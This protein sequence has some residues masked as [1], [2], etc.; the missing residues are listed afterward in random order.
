CQ[1]VKKKHTALL[2]PIP[3]CNQNKLFLQFAQVRTTATLAAREAFCVKVWCANLAS[4]KTQ[5]LATSL[6][7]QQFKPQQVK[8]TLNSY[9]SLSKAFAFCQL[10]LTSWTSQ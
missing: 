10:G 6:N 4:L 7:S 9:S 2:Q 3:K 5:Q 1:E 8:P